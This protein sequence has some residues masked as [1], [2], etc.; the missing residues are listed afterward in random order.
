MGG[1]EFY[2]QKEF[3]E[4]M[5][6][7]S[8][9]DKIRVSGSVYSFTLIHPIRFFPAS[10]L[11]FQQLD[12]ACHTFRSCF[13]QAECQGTEAYFLFVFS[14][15]LCTALLSTLSHVEMSLSIGGNALCCGGQWQ[16]ISSERKTSSGEEDTVGDCRRWEDVAIL[17]EF[18]AFAMD[19]IQGLIYEAWHLILF[20]VF[21]AVEN[22]NHCEF[23]QLRDFLIR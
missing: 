21:V 17:M 6:D 5:E 14:H 3:D 19:Q 11:L 22:P 2:P 1:I 9:N 12:Q 18:H 13:L 4:D 8:D 16:R 10:L 20:D 7:K 15:K 23:A